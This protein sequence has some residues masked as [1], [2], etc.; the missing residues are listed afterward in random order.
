[1]PSMRRLSL[2]KVMIDAEKRQ[3]YLEAWLLVG[4]LSPHDLLFAIE[5][6]ADAADHFGPL[7]QERFGGRLMIDN[8]WR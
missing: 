5:F 2:P 7:L 4:T 3:I 6:V 1:M 8:G